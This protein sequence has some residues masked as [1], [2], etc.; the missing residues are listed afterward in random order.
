MITRDDKLEIFEN[1]WVD[2]ELPKIKKLEFD[3]ND[4]ESIESVTR[5]PKLSMSAA[6]FVRSSRFQFVDSNSGDLGVVIEQKRGFWN[7]LAFWRKKDSSTSIE[8]FFTNIKNNV[9]ELEIVQ[10][11]A[12]GYELAI[13]NAKKAGQRALV[14][15]L[16]GGLNAYA[17]ETQLA[18][19][20]LTK[21]LTE[22]TV[23]KFYKQSKKG[24][25]L[26]WIRNFSRTIPEE[27]VAKNDVGL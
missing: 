9:Q 3:D 23:V 13:V 27:I 16:Q 22:E 14:E 15:Q 8:E 2:A 1:F 24:L 4:E 5:S 10:S 12:K 20:G 18:A 25:R 26:D 21:F 6:R 11:R 17:V 19:I 7:K